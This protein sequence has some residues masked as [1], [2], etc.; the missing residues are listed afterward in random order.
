MVNPIT[1]TPVQTKY[2]RRHII[3]DSGYTAVAAGTVCGITG[4]RQ[5]RFPY[6]MKVHK[7]SAYIAAIT[8]FLHWG[9]VKRWDKK[10]SSILTRST[11]AHKS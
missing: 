11:S 1:S 7:Y 10:F 2:G 5:I 6:K 3:R 9:A 8:T 4:F